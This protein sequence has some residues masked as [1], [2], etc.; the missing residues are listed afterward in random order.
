[1]SFWVD[2][3][4]YLRKNFS[5]FTEFHSWF[6]QRWKLVL[7]LS[8]SSSCNA[9]KHLPQVRTVTLRSFETVCTCFFA[10]ETLTWS[11]FIHAKPGNELISDEPIPFPLCWFCLTSLVNIPLTR[12]VILRRLLHSHIQ[13]HMISAGE[14]HNQAGPSSEH[15]LSVGRVPPWFVGLSLHKADQARVCAAPST[16]CN[17]RYQK[18]GNLPARCRCGATIGPVQ[19]RG[20][21]WFLRWC[22]LI[23]WKLE[24]CISHIK[25]HWYQWGI[26]ANASGLMGVHFMH[27]KLKYFKKAKTK[28]FL[29][30]WEYYCLFKWPF[31]KGYQTQIYTFPQNKPACVG[32]CTGQFIWQCYSMEFCCCTSAHLWR[33][34]CAVILLGLPGSISLWWVR[35][36]AQEIL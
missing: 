27:W 36:T 29:I 14:K 1:M 33:P 13:S 34:K 16:V 31:P 26:M 11:Q 17:A 30:V 32:Q 7:V 3:S 28:W 8:P 35:R 2:W 6:Y 9:S 5:S 10:V 25:L 21:R 23:N 15:W 12:L 20:T 19:N 22:W 18:C 4:F 24:R